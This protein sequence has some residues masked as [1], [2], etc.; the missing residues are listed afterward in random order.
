MKICKVSVI[1]LTKNRALLLKQAIFSV[2]AQTFKNFEI[3]VINDGSTDETEETVEE[4]IKNGAPVNLI[5]HEVSFGKTYSRN[6]GLTSSLGE[7]VCFLDDDDEWIDNGKLQMQS[8]YLDKHPQAVI[9]GSSMLVVDNT[10][11]SKILGKKKRSE[12]DFLIR[13]TMLLKNNF[14]TSTVM[15][16]RRE[17]LAAGGIPVGN[18]DEA[19]DYSL[20]LRL[21][22]RGKMYNFR[23]TF[24]KYRQPNYDKSRLK[25]ILNE[26]MGLMEKFKNLYPNFFLAKSILRLRIAYL[27]FWANIKMR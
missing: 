22:L 3:V 11:G 24:V 25:T 1:I 20:W 8:D 27:N 5:N 26:Q 21:G 10:T 15:F 14:F 19:E 23:E 13:Q 18:K 7:Y 16:R 4:I 9:V 2:L 6:Q 12:S 17:A